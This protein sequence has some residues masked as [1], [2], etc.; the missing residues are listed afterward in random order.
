MESKEALFD[1]CLRRADRSDLPEPPFPVG[2]PAP[3]ATLA[4]VRTLV[5]A[6]AL[7]DALD[8]ALTEPPTKPARE[9]LARLVDGVY[10][11]LSAHRIAIRL[12]GSSAND[13]PELSA[14]W[15]GGTRGELNR[16]LAVYFERR[17]ASGRL[18]AMPD[19]VCAARLFTETIHWFAVNRF[20]DPLPD[21]IDEG[22]ARRTVRT[23]LLRTFLP[24]EEAP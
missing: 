18:R 13:V 10:S 4:F 20:F 8:E 12:I 16:R 9:E 24:R 23:A 19:A 1:Q 17:A 2:A 11:V 5:E 21:P 22:L 6:H 15:Y 3:G 14:L 7:T